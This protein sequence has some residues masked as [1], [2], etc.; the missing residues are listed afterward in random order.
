[1]QLRFHGFEW[2]GA[3]L[4]LTV[5]SFELRRVEPFTELDVSYRPGGD[6]DPTGAFNSTAGSLC[7]L[8]ST[9]IDGEWLQGVFS[10]EML[11]DAYGNSARLWEGEFVCTIDS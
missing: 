8:R 9:L 11:N 3:I 2:R 5:P 10:C 7:Q 1:M 6:I 4:T